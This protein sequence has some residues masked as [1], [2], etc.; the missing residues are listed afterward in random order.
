MPD[1]RVA[2]RVNAICCLSTA[3]FRI[4]VMDVFLSLFVLAQQLR[5]MMEQVVLSQAIREGEVSNYRKSERN[6][7]FELIL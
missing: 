4:I 3:A 1:E 6:G 5:M 7:G 2:M